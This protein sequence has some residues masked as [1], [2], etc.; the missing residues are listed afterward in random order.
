MNFVNYISSVVHG[1]VETRS[2]A[3]KT[4]DRWEPKQCEITLHRR[5]FI[6]PKSFMLYV[7]WNIGFRD[8]GSGN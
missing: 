1:K 2:I 5:H 4:T 7:R 6:H 3:R 8:E